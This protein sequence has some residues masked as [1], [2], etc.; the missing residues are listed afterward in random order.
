MRRS[1]AKSCAIVTRKSPLGTSAR[2][3]TMANRAR[4]SSIV[5]YSSARNISPSRKAAS[6]RRLT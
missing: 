4:N 5:G 1:S 6:A 2:N 3:G